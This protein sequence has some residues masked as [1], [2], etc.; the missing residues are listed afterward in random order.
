MIDSILTRKTFQPLTA[1]QMALLRQQIPVTGPKIDAAFAQLLQT[2]IPENM[3]KLG[4]LVAS[5]GN[6][7][8]HLLI[9]QV[10]QRAIECAVRPHPGADLPGISVDRRIP[11]CLGFPGTFRVC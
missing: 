11:G 5:G 9:Y 2:N 3:S 8:A 4:G 7:A 6:E 10:L 1:G